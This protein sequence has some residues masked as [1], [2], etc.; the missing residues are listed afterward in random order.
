MH[1]FPAGRGLSR[2]GKNERKEREDLK[3]CTLLNL[4]YIC[5]YESPG[6][7]TDKYMENLK[8]ASGEI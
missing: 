1:L 6:K 4:L 8:Q 7:I 5:L 2:R 3:P